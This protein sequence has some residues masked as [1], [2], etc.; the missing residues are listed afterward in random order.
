MQC[1]VAE[2][3]LS[4]DISDLIPPS[5]HAMGK[6]E[7]SDV[8]LSC[9]FSVR[10]S[11]A[12]CDGTRKANSERNRVFQ[13]VQHW[14][15]WQNCYTLKN[16]LRPKKSCCFL[17]STRRLRA[18]R[19]H[20]FAMKRCHIAAKIS[21]SIGNLPCSV[22]DK[23]WMN[24][25]K[26]TRAEFEP[27]TSNIWLNDFWLAPPPPPPPAPNKGT[28][29][30][31]NR[32]TANIGLVSSVGTAPARH[33]EVAGSNPALV[34]FSLFIHNLSNNVPNQ[35]PLWFITCFVLNDFFT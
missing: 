14:W 15:C 18:M 30:W 2:W 32:E 33:P 23:F 20:L 3:H 1:S 8:I 9:R 21:G 35:F 29:Y 34:N 22:L 11:K 31:Q 16:I 12:I 4:F 5:Q 24:K 26:L 17:V 27:V 6:I 19:Q 28:V 25:E 10:H 7:R 13:K